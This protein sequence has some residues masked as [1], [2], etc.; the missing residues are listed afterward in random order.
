MDILITKIIKMHNE[1]LKKNNDLEI[2]PGA[3]LIS[4]TFI[5]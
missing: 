4:G 1:V 5:L 2:I 3:A